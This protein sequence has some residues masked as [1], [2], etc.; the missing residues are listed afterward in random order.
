MAFSAVKFVPDAAGSVAGK[1]ASGMVPEVNCV[2]FSAVR[3]TPDA[4][5][6]VAGKRAS[7]IVP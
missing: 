4:A 6:R 5:G 7:G 2:A 1:R 3:F